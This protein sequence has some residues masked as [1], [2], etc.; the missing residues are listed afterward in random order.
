ADVL[1]GGVVPVDESACDRVQPGR[2]VE[3]VFGAGLGD[4]QGHRGVVGPFAGVETERTAVVHDDRGVGAGA[5]EFVAGAEGVAGRGAQ[6]G[7]GEM[8]VHEQ[9]PFPGP[10]ATEAVAGVVD[11][12][13]YRQMMPGRYDICGPPAPLSRPSRP[14]PRRSARPGPGPSSRSCLRAAAGA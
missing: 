11:A 7:A 9:T 12:S 3:S 5:G 8:V 1:R 6:Q 10:D 4:G 14:G 2:G 13:V